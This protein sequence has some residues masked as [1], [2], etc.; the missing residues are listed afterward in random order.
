MEIRLP[1]IM[2]KKQNEKQKGMDVKIIDF[3]FA[4]K[5][6][7]VYYPRLNRNIQWGIEDAKEE[8]LNKKSYYNYKKITFHND[9]F[10]LKAVM[11]SISNLGKFTD[12]AKKLGELNV[13]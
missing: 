11:D 10:M 9:V 5:S 1:N 7:A 6:G 3:E 2:V 4:G 13:Y 8:F 12:F